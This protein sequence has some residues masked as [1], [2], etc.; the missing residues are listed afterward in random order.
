M[1]RFKKELKEDL[2]QGRKI[3]YVAEE[4]GITLSH[5]S[6]ILNGN[7][8]TQKTTAYCIVKCC[9]QEKEITDYFERG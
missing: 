4:I 2:L 5:L 3:S 6:Q 7:Y 9:Q 8:T 1:Y